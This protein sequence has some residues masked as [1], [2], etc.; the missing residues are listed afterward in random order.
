[1]KTAPFL[2][3]MDGIFRGIDILDLPAFVFAPT[4]IFSTIKNDVKGILH[5][6]GKARD[7]KAEYSLVGRHRILIGSS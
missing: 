4:R 1:M 3:P 7:Q 2:L 5:T 6:K